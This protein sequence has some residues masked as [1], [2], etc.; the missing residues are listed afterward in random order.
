MINKDP[1]ESEY[2]HRSDPE[3]KMDG[4][5]SIDSTPSVSSTPSADQRKKPIISHRQIGLACIG[6]VFLGGLGVGSWAML[7]DTAKG[8]QY[9]FYGL[10][11]TLAAME[12]LVFGIAYSSSYI[13]VLLHPE[14]ESSRVLCVVVI[15]LTVCLRGGFALFFVQV[16]PTFVP[17][18]TVYTMQHVFL[19]IV[20]AWWVFTLA[21]VPS[22]ANRA[23]SQYKAKGP[24]GVRLPSTNLEEKDFPKFVIVCPVYNE[25]LEL[26]TN[27]INSILMQEYD[28]SKIEIHLSFDDESLSPTYLGAVAA[29]SPDVYTEYPQSLKCHPKGSNATVYIHRWPHGGKRHA[30]LN[31]WKFFKRHT[32]HPEGTIL[33]LTDSDNYMMPNCLH[34]LAVEFATQ[35]SKMAFAG[36]MTCFAGKGKW[37]LVKILQDCE[38][39]CNELSRLFEIRLGTISCLPGAFTAIRFEAISQVAGIYFESELPM[40]TLTQYH[41]YVLGEDRYLTHLAHKALKPYAISFSPV[42]RCKTDPPDS[43]RRYI[44]QRRRWLLGA[45]GNEAFM[46]AGPILWKKY[47]LMMIMKIFQTAWRSC[48]FCQLLV[49]AYCVVELFAAKSGDTIMKMFVFSIILPIIIAYIA[50]SSAGLMT[51]HYKTVLLWPVMLIWQNCLQPCIDFFAIITWTERTWGGARFQTPDSASEG[52][53]LTADIDNSTVVHVQN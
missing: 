37:N 53:F 24:P 36:Y 52:S 35:P 40:K 22:I 47:P 50:G 29:F 25:T 23:H 21:I 8:F 4:F 33:I 27:G 10:F 6:A 26:L 15:I 42:V 49:C 7:Q 48:F 34:N 11:A 18:D 9:F 1:F 12:I 19:A 39:T 13:N 41:Q 2:N 20:G 38:Y 46:L 30:Q 17:S 3:V 45:I 28:D 51:G 32:T 16:S 5:P 14:K 43:T 44:L 31:S